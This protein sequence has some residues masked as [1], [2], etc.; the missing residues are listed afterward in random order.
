MYVLPCGASLAVDT[1]RPS[2]VPTPIQPFNAGTL[3]I[4]VWRGITLRKT[5]TWGVQDPYVRTQLRRNLGRGNADDTSNRASAAAAMATSSSPAT[6]PRRDRRPDQQDKRLSQMK[7]DAHVLDESDEDLPEQLKTHGRTN[8]HFRGGSEPVWD[9]THNNHMAL[10]LCPE[11]VA[12]SISIWNCNVM[13]D[14]KCVRRS[15][16]APSPSVTSLQHSPSSHSP[17]PLL[18]LCA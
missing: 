7:L 16:A 12:V 14:D 1:R 18:C 11:A 17:S 10:E 6:S 3:I 9:R 15:D 4:A 2:Q 13:A 8:F 5:Q